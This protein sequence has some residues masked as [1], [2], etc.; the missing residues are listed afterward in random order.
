M[1]TISRQLPHENLRRRK[2]LNYPFELCDE[3]W[4]KRIVNSSE[5]GKKIGKRRLHSRGLHEC[6]SG[7]NEVIKQRQARRIETG[8]EGVRLRVTSPD[9]DGYAVISFQPFIMLQ[10]VAVL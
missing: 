1:L 6:H 8:R 3:Y 10:E 4:W 5:P 2:R 9:I 7:L